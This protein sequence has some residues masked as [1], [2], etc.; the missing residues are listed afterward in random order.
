[1]LTSRETKTKDFYS[2]HTSSSSSIIKCIFFVSFACFLMPSNTEIT[3][4]RNSS[5]VDSDHGQETM[6]CQI[7]PRKQHKAGTAKESVRH[8]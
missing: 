5:P 7:R 8:F 2:F 1:M 4:H 3:V 6:F